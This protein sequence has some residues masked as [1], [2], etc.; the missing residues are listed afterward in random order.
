MQNPEIIACLEWA[1]K[2]KLLNVIVKE[3]SEGSNENWRRMVQGASECGIFKTPFL[4]F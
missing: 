2:E 1:G 3:F 4:M